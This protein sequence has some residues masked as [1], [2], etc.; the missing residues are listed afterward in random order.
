MPLFL[1]LA[2]AA[3]RRLFLLVA[4]G[5][6]VI[7]RCLLVVLPSFFLFEFGNRLPCSGIFFG[8]CFGGESTA[9]G[10]D[11]VLVNSA[12]RPKQQ[13]FSARGC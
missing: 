1:D 5:V 6:L 9:V 7:I 2:L 13:I 4:S 3:G 11:L 8:V 12:K 10:E